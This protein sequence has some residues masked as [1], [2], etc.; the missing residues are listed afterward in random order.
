MDNQEIRRKILEYI[1]DKNEQ[2]PQYM[3]QRDEVKQFLNINDAKLDNNVLYLESKGYLKV[4]KNIGSFFVYAQITSEGIDLVENPNQ[5]NTLFPVRI[6]QNIIQH[7]TG[8]IIGD[9]NIQ[10]INLTNSFT[11]IYRDINEKNPKNKEQI[12]IEVKKI[13]EELKKP[14]PDKTIIDKSIEFL[15]NNASWMVPTIIEI[16]KTAIG[17]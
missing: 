15:K 13:E 14:S 7:S 8:V 4:G 2:Q 5:F 17:V 11:K 3:A 12:I 1:Y 10:K 9:N 6:T 16:I